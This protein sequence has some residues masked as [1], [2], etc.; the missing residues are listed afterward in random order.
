MLQFGIFFPAIG[1]FKTMGRILLPGRSEET[2]IRVQT[3]QG[4]DVPNYRVHE[5]TAFEQNTFQDYERGFQTV[6]W[7]TEAIPSYNCHGLTFASRRTSIQETASILLILREDGYSEVGRNEV[8]PG[9]IVLYYATGG[10]IEHSG[11]VVEVA[12]TPRMFRVVSK[13]GKYKEALHWESECPYSATN[14]R[15]FR[16]KHEPNRPT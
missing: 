4:T 9:D 1:S 5:Y 2:S 11:I 10:D 16:V 13:W 6:I 12:E 8:L 14:M 15:Y 7:R 3:R